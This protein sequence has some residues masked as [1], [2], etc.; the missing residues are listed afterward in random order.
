[1]DQQKETESH[2][3][4]LGKT[5]SSMQM[6][7][8]VDNSMHGELMPSQFPNNEVGNGLSMLNPKIKNTRYERDIQEIEGKDIENDE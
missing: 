7:D 5:E 3:S 8:I 1:M 4:I 6:N 2:D